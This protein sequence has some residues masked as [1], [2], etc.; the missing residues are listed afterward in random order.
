MVSFGDDGGVAGM[1]GAAK[2]SA[3]NS[4]N[5]SNNRR[6]MLDIELQKIA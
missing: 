4:K 5:G 3:G 1:G 6:M 2:A